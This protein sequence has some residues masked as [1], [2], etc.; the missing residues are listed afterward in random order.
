M[1]HRVNR[2]LTRAVLILLSIVLIT[3][4]VV[5]P[6]LAKYTQTRSINISLGFKPA[7]VEI[8]WKSLHE[9]RLMRSQWLDDIGQS[10]ND[11][12]SKFTVV[13]TEK[14]LTSVPVDKGDDRSYF[15]TKMYN[16]TSFTK[17]EYTF[18]AKNNRA[19]GYAGVIFAY[20]INGK[21]PY[22]AYGEF[23]NRSNVGNCIH[24]C[25]RRGHYDAEHY[26][27]VVNSDVVTAVVKET[28]D[29]Y[30]QYK[31]IYEGLN[32]KFCYLNTS[33]EYV[34][35]GSTITLPAGSKV[36]VGVYSRP[37]SKAANEDCTVSLKNCVLTAKNY[38]TIDYLKGEIISLVKKFTLKVATFNI[39]RADGGYDNIAAAIQKSGADIIVLQEVEYRTPYSKYVDQAGE[40][41]LRA[42]YAGSWTFKAMEWN[43]D[44]FVIPNYKKDPD[45]TPGYGV[46]IISK[47]TLGYPEIVG[48]TSVDGDQRIF[49]RVGIEIHNEVIQFCVTQL[50]ETP[51]VREQQ[52]DEVANA[53]DKLAEWDDVILM[54]DFNTDNLQEFEPIEKNG[55]SLV[56]NP[57]APIGTYN[58]RAFD[59][60]VHSNIFTSS[61]GVAVES[62][63][64]DHYLLYTTLTYDE[65]RLPMMSK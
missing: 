51:K 55:F 31:V 16:I 58:N 62:T 33:G 49:A 23:D 19:R 24:I 36:C 60:I 43:G 10:K 53:I 21:F 22:L 61:G 59:N 46:A 54:G 47:Y 29:G 45:D 11:Y 44:R 38:K 8:N 56:N 13:E 7:Y 32:V 18:E 4:S 6:I 52:F 48:L 64:S 30:G 65:A 9:E 34:Q 42:G 20:D 35:L 39:N 2:I 41:A 40:I 12:T 63:A 26:D 37:G 28:D 5:S 27:C 1:L 17:Y 15:S 57:D 50:S 3:T 14:E 25:Y